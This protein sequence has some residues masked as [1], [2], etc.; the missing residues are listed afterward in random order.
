MEFVPL[1]LT[2]FIVERFCDIRQSKS[3]ENIQNGGGT[4]LVVSQH[5]TAHSLY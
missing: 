2:S 4:R 5:T 1:R 3:N